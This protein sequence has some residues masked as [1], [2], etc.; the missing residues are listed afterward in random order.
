MVCVGKG[1]EAVTDVRILDY[2]VKSSKRKGLLPTVLEDLLAAR[3]RAKND[4]KKEKDPFKRAVLDGRQLALKVR[5]ISLS[6]PCQAANVRC[7]SLQIQYT[8][9]PAR[10][11]VNCPVYQSRRPLLRT[12][13]K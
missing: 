6:V 12:V 5:K 13:V 11:S 7:R 8:G 1:R 10:R 4:L 3:K 2:F 9:S